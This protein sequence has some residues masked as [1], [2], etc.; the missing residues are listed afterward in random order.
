MWNA[1]K[2]DFC[3]D[4]LVRCQY[5]DYDKAKAVE[6]IQRL[7]EGQQAEILSQCV[8]CCACREYCPTDADPYDLILRA[9]EKFKAFPISEQD[10]AMYDLAFQLPTEVILGDKDKPALSLCVMES[11]IPPGALDG[12]LFEG[13]TIVKGGDYFCL[14]GYVHGGMESPIEDHAQSFIDN[15][16]ALGKDIVF[17]HDDCYAMVK[18]KVKDY[19]ISVPFNYRHIFEYLL[20][21][22]KEHQD[23][24][25]KLNIKVAY[26]R[27]C[28]SRYTPEKDALL[29]EIF[30]LIGAERPKRTYEGENA[31]C[32]TA[33]M[34]RIDKEHAREF[35][36]KNIDDAIACGADALITLCPVCHRILR[37]PTSERG[38]KEIYITDLCRMALGEKSFPA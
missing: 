17:L 27:P 23:R 11:Q 33:P 2:C 1:S 21:Y 6:E 29:D 26:Q 37:R 34:V 18:E 10:A 7:M 19:G 25:K 3:G 4:C 36:L 31:L 8:T 5:V 12:P 24:I 16:A 15:L 9:Q 38:L 32:C 35:Q 13:M 30:E 20:D 22:L 14:I 28:A